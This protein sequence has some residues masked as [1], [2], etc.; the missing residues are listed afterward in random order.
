MTVFDPTN[1]KALRE[2]REAYAYILLELSKAASAAMAKWGSSEATRILTASAVAMAAS[3]TKELM[4]SSLNPEMRATFE[5][6]VQLAV[7]HEV[8]KAQFVNLD[9]PNPGP[10]N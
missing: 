8:A 7:K 4:L 5:L 9:V 3:V 10:L 6:G 2:Y 1:E